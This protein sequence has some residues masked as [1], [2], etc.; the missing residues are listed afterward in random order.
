MDTILKIKY[1]SA[2]RWHYAKPALTFH[3]GIKFASLFI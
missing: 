2:I 1:P 3:F